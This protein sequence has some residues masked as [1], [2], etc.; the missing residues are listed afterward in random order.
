MKQV[1]AVYLIILSCLLESVQS[2]DSNTAVDLRSLADLICFQNKVWYTT[3]SGNYK[4]F[5][6]VSKAIICPGS[7]R[8]V[9]NAADVPCIEKSK[10]WQRI[11]YQSMKV[12]KS[13]CQYEGWDTN[14]K[15]VQDKLQDAGQCDNY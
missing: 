15:D 13:V 14:T 1:L 4:T 3:N 5:C 11:N 12:H 9:Q 8:S 6:E 2:T 10:G 7:S